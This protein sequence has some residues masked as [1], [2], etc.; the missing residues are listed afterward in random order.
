MAEK[1]TSSLMQPS[2]CR[3]H[4]LRQSPS[5]NK[6]LCHVQD[7]SGALT[8]FS[9]KSWLRFQACA[10]R[11]N[12]AIWAKMNGYWEEG[13]K[14][15]YH[16]RCYQVY[17][18]KVKVARAVE[19]IHH[20]L[21]EDPLEDNNSDDSIT[22]PPPAKRVSRSQ[23]DAFDINK[24]AICQQDKTMLTKN[25][26]ARSR[27]TL[28]LNMTATGSASL[29]KAAQ[30]RD[31]RRLL[32]QIQGQDTIAIEIKYHKSC[33]IQYVRAGALAKLEEQNC[34]DEDIASKS[35][36]RAFSNIREYVNVT[37]LKERKAVKMSELLEGYIRKLSQEGVNAP[38]YR[39][40]K[41]KNRFIKSFGSRLSYRQPLDRS[42]S[43]IVYS[44]HVTT[45]EVIETVI[46]TVLNTSDDQWADEE[47]I[48]EVTPE[49]KE[50]VKYLHIYHTAKMIRRLV[51]EMKPVMTW[52]PTEDDLDCSDTVVPDL[53]YN[54]FAWICASDVEYSN[55]RV[56]GVSA[57][58]R[59]LVLSLA[60]DLIHC[61]SRGRIKT[62][63]HVTLPLT[64]KS[65]TGNAELVT[66]LNRFGH[67]LSYPQIEELE[68][69]LAEK[70][71]AKEQHGIIVP[72]VCSMG[73]PA[74]FCWDNNDLLEETLSGK[75]ERFVHDLRQSPFSA[76]NAFLN[77]QLTSFTVI[78]LY[79]RLSTIYTIL[80]V[81]VDCSI[82][83]CIFF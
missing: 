24:C 2:Q 83:D 37:V 11:R 6:C 73:V 62:P 68:T 14:G 80:F 70:E 48:E 13:P 55:K 53:L 10:K 8:N 40:S 43:E 50:D 3:K 21:I 26:G 9:E 82:L 4:Q 58:V 52:P 31:D 71:I 75:L 51:T 60:Q 22:E 66:I 56:C 5:W 67:A 42:Q 54:M 12:D 78:P 76:E 77:I 30:I 45:G 46:E 25:K 19:K 47:E 7:E 61:V 38:S 18:D 28:S 39:S 44:S 57:E 79:Y 35:Y 63:K 72:S 29:L 59:R 65:L 1:Q 34:E 17:T 20:T 81:S 27:E 23:I 33:Y 41:L 64:L 69:A 16:R 49:A 15:K 36:N 74:V 32:L